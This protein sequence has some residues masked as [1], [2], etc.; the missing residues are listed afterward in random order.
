LREIDIKNAY[1]MCYHY[2]IISR[3]NSNNKIKKSQ[4]K[5]FTLDDI[6]S[7]D[8]PELI[9]ETLKNKIK[10]KKPIINYLK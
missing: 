4:Y 8:Y 2:R 5:K 1:L 6:M 3:E 10:N 9:D 7:F